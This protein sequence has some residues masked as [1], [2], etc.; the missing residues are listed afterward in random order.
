MDALVKLPVREKIG[1]FKYIAGD[2]IQEEYDEILTNL[3][4]E[5]DKL[6]Q[7]EES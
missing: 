2:R 3:H 6:T 5:T 1:R 7:K 4:R